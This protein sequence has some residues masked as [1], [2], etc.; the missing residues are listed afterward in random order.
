MTT[1]SPQNP[2]RSV[3]TNNL[4]DILHQLGISLAVSTYQAGKVILVYANLKK[5][6]H[7]T[8][9]EI[10]Q[11]QTFIRKEYHALLNM[12]NELAKKAEKVLLESFGVT[13]DEI[14]EELER[15]SEKK[16]KL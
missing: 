14:R 8:T 6:P 12:Y 10:M 11:H 13:V 2:L 3:H 7:R 15:T 9:K 5:I 4:P 16:L 1:N